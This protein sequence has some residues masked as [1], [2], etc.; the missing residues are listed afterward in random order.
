MP[1]PTASEHQAQDLAARLPPLL[2]AAERIAAT[3]AQGAHGRRRTGPGETFWQFRR[4]QPGDPA[5]A[6]DWRQSARSDPLFV[7][8]TEWSAAQTGWLWRDPSASMAWRSSPALPEKRERAELLLLALAALLLRGGERVA[9]LSGALAPT[10]G[11]GALGRLARALATET[12]G[13]GLP[14]APPPRH[15]ALVLIGDFLAPLE[16]IDAQVG[17]LAAAGASGHL[18]QVL[19]PAEETLP[20]RGRVRFAGLEGEGETVVRRTEDIRTAYIERLNAHRD[21]LAAI[22]RSAGW[23]FALHHTDQPPQLA[24]LAL[25]AALAAPRTGWAR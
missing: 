22:A 12:A 25:H 3:V 7:R 10:G 15:A 16:D 5:T 19:D 24:L 14:T 21:G 6:I 23:T 9:L 2:V 13:A 18:L 17:R 20:Y 8:E 1:I 11:S 4:Y